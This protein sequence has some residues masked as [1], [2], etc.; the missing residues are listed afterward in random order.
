M[1]WNFTFKRIEPL[2]LGF[3]SPTFKLLSEIQSEHANNYATKCKQM[4]IFT[5][6]MEPKTLYLRC[7][8]KKKRNVLNL[9]FLRNFDLEI[10]HRRMY[11]C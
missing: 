7:Q 3:D 5:Y 6:T 4:L 9:S 10:G 1:Q 11:V 2:L 8:K